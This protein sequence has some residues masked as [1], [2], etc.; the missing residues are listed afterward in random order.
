MEVPDVRVLLAYSGDLRH[1]Q[2]PDGP[3]PRPVRVLRMGLEA[4][5]IRE[6]GSRLLTEGGR[7]VF[8][9]AVIRDLTE[10]RNRHC[11]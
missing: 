8:K 2:G 3:L 7:E 11:R 5:G 10:R 4:L 9:A 1:V 6:C